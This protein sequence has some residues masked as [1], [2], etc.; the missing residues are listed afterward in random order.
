MQFG[1]VM[2]KS[3]QNTGFHGVNESDVGG[4]LKSW[5][6]PLANEHLAELD[7]LL[8]REK[9]NQDDDMVGIKK[10]RE[11]LERITD[12]LRYFCKSNPLHV[13]KIRKMFS[14][15]LIQF[16]QKNYF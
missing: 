9:I 6:E 4:L 10:R 2:C 15:E 14:R 13:S 1:N 12:T 7:K 8:I 16:C 3:Y 5:A 11:I